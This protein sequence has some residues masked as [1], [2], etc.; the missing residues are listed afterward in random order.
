[1]EPASIVAGPRRPWH[2]LV[3]SENP[4]S[5]AEAIVPFLVEGV[6]ARERV[7]AVLAPETRSAVME[8]LADRADVAALEADDAIRG[9]EPGDVY[10]EA[11]FDAERQLARF[12]E[13]ADEALDDGFSGLRV[14]G[15]ITPLAVRH[16]DDL[17]RWERTADAFQARNPVTGLCVL[18]ASAVEPR[19]VDA[20]DVLHA[21]T[22]TSRATFHVF[23][24][25]E[26]VVTFSG[27][28][29]ATDVDLFATTLDAVGSGL[30]EADYV[31]DLSELRYISHQ[32]LTTLDGLGAR[33][34]SSIAIVNA[35][36]AVTRVI[37]LLDLAHLEVTP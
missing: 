31:V 36:P 21:P 34:D 26:P 12:R 28:L 11:A 16:P 25:L 3:A 20:I 19:L 24:G 35:S 37:A 5:S 4:V 32:A 10:P 22:P 29:D 13:M 17:L 27:D 30:F 33:L 1:M 6:Q 9:A 23:S 18:D 2:T 15:D 8:R 14:A 7:L